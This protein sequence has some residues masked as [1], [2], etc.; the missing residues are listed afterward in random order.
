MLVV[1]RNFTTL[2]EYS[3]VIPNLMHDAGNS[4]AMRLLL[5]KKPAAG[6]EAHSQAKIPCCLLVWGSL[7][8]VRPGTLHKFSA[9]RDKACDPLLVH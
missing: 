8:G 2:P 9:A 3:W 1:V 6:P 4:G 7:R 5:R